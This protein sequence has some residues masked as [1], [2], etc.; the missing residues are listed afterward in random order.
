MRFWFDAATVEVAEKQ[1]AKERSFF[2]YG[3]DWGDNPNDG[4][5][6][7]DGIV[8][9]D[10]GHTGKAA[11]VKRIYQAVHATPAAGDHPD[12]D[13]GHPHQRVPLHQPP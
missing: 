3:G 13:D 5:F 1:P 12:L 9:A 4:A 6:V 11:E 10:R 8:N 7:A 2:A